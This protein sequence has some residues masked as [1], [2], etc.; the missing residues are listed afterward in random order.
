MSDER[1]RPTRRSR[2][3]ATDTGAAAPAD[4]VEGQAKRFFRRGEDAEAPESTD[5][6][7]DG[8]KDDTEAGAGDDPDVEGHPFYKDEVDAPARPWRT[9]VRRGRFPSRFAR[10]RVRRTC[11]D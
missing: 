1:P 2:S 9:G 4:E 6:E 10:E 7:E 5:L 3:K 8:A 11:G